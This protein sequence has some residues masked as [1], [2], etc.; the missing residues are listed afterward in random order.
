MKNNKDIIIICATIALCILA[1]DIILTFIAGLYSFCAIL[2]I[3]FIIS[4]IVLIVFATKKDK[5]LKK[6]YNPLTNIEDTIILKL[7]D[8]KSESILPIRN[9]QTIE[10]IDDTSIKR[11]LQE[12]R[13]KNVTKEVI[14]EEL[15]K[16]IFIKDLKDKMKLFEQ[17]Q[18]LLRQKEEEQELKELNELIKNKNK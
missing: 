18:E 12:Q 15:G 6:K 17:E 4:L 8:L 9:S 1:I 2:I 16:T 14:E 10:I 5:I 7:E 3:L 11:N 13:E